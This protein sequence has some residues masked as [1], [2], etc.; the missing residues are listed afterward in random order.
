MATHVCVWVRGLRDY[1]RVCGDLR[2]YARVCG[3]LRDYA[4]V[5]LHLIIVDITSGM[6]M[7]LDSWVHTCA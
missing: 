2:D 4:R 7:P 1:A 3:G 6:M 5:C